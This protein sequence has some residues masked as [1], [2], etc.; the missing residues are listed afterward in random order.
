MKRITINNKDYTIEFSI[1]ATMY[2]ECIED[3][4]D[5]IIAAGKMQG[6][7]TSNKEDEE[8][9]ANN[10]IDTFKS[11]VSEIPKRALNMF[12]GGLLE[13]HGANGDRTVNSIADAKVL[14][15]TY[16][17]ESNLSLYE[18]LNDMVE[19]M[20]EDHFFDM[21]GVEKMLSN[22]T[23]KKVPQDHKR[24]SKNGES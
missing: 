10:I 6:D 12:Y 1:E 2:N 16:I 21:I 23:P 14:L 20:G 5:M 15:T 11:S 7:I 3:V 13:H 19:Q 17:K 24:K 4:M 18:V 22:A 8:K 9:L